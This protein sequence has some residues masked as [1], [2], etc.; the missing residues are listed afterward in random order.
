MDKCPNEPETKNGFQD[1]DGCPDTPPPTKLDML[2][3]RV[4]FAFNS[5]AITADTQAVLKEV[6]QYMKEEPGITKVEVGG[7]TDNKGNAKFNKGLSQKR[8]DAI[9]A[10]LIKLGVEKPRL[11]AVGYGMEH[12]LVDADTDEARA[13]NR[14]VEFKVLTGAPAKP[15]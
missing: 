14:R 7:H 5:A 6:A 9:I 3:K 11:E 10:A 15:Y 4:N 13:Q 2:A 8:A 12:P 1:E